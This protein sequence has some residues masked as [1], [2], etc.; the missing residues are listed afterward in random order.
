M[1]GCSK[2]VDNYM[3][4]MGQEGIYTNVIK[5]ES[6]PVQALFFFVVILNRI[7]LFALVWNQRKSISTKPLSLRNSLISKR[8]YLLKNAKIYIAW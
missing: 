6:Q 3:M 8:T 5:Y 2:S 4:Y 7:A 1:T